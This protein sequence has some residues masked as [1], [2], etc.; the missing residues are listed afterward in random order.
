M[1]YQ[2][3]GNTSR[4]IPLPYQ[5]HCHCLLCQPWPPPLRLQRPWRRRRRGHLPVVW[6]HG[7]SPIPAAPPGSRCRDHA[8][9]AQSGAAGGAM[10]VLAC[11]VPDANG[12]AAKRVRSSSNGDGPPSEMN[13]GRAY[14]GRK[15]SME[16]PPLRALVKRCWTRSGT[17]ELT[18]SNGG[19]RT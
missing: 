5:R 14:R 18:A 8:I 4:P 13:L 9:W 15:P 16:R 19:R 3:H 1:S 17:R 12:A 11:V 10:F 2:I 6:L 7:S